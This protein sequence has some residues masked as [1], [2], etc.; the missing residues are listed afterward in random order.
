LQVTGSLHRFQRIS[1][2]FAGV[3][4]YS[5]FCWSIIDAEN[6]QFSNSAL[7]LFFGVWLCGFAVLL[8]VAHFPLGLRIGI[9]RI[10]FARALWCSLGVVLISGLVNSEQRFLT[11]VAAFFGIF[12][13]SL[14]LSLKEVCWVSGTTFV[15]Y[16]IA[17]LLRFS[18]AELFQ[19]RE[20]SSIFGFT[21]LLGA[22]LL[23]AREVILLRA[24]NVDRREALFAA[25]QTMENLAM[26]DELTGLFNRRQLLEILDQQKALSDRGV[27]DFTILYC[28]LDYFKRINDEHGHHVGDQTLVEFARVADTVVRSQ[29]F[30]ARLGGEEFLLVL[31]NSNSVIANS[32]AERLIERT[33]EIQVLSD[34]AKPMITVSIGVASYHSGESV[35]DLLQRADKALYQ[36]KQRG[37][38]RLVA[39][40]ETQTQ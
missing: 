5:A 27:L 40:N 7:G 18:P 39:A 2:V 15:G 35:D 31:V 26:R 36:A 23:M 28:D 3:L 12:Y 1:V 37:R 22:T 8:P 19:F 34:Q 33:R 24:T 4:V 14:H 10:A 9:D 38:D 11:V 16:L 17:A 32:I 13:A 6:A 29:D 21:L 20:L 25:M 30:V